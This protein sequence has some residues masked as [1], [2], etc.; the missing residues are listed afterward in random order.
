MTPMPAVSSRRRMLAVWY[1]LG[2]HKWRE[3]VDG[4][5]ASH[6]PLVYDKCL[7]GANFGNPEDGFAASM[8][9]AWDYVGRH[10]LGRPTTLDMWLRAHALAMDHVAAYDTR[11]PGKLRR[12]QERNFIMVPGSWP[13]HENGLDPVTW[14]EISSL[15]PRVCSLEPSETDPAGHNLVFVHM[16][17]K[18]RRRNMDYFLAKFYDDLAH[19]ADGLPPGANHDG[20]PESEE[21]RAERELLHRRQREQ[22]ITLNLVTLCASLQQTMQR[23]EPSKDGNQRVSVLFLCKHLVECGLTPTALWFPNGADITSRSE[24]TRHVILGMRAWR[25]LLEIKVRQ[26]Q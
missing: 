7:H 1:A 13:G 9:R 15:R 25:E 14:A 11:V 16:K 21:Q 24:W 19:V 22:R 12:A 20:A 6:G 17:R 4:R 2:P 5:H 3:A 10:C 23:S 18:R 8:A 26:E